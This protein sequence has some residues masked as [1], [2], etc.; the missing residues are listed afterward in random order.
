MS[1]AYV[2]I[3]LIYTNDENEDVEV[4]EYLDPQ[5]L[6]VTYGGDLVECIQ[7]ECAVPYEW[8]FAPTPTIDDI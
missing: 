6:F 5:T 8:H 3:A 2:R 4:T 1:K 7:N